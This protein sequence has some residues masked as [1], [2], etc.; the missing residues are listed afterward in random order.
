DA[1]VTGRPAIEPLAADLR[2]G[3]DGK[4]DA[5]LKI[6]AGLLGVGLDEL[7]HRDQARRQRRLAIVGVAAT[8]GCILFAGLALAAW[9]A[10]NEAEAQR[11]LAAQKSL[12]A[13]RTAAF[14]V[15]LF[16]E[17]DPSEARGRSI[18]VSEVLERG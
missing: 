13:Q 11:A 3:A 14:M 10:R 6:V 15:S 5:R 1:D 9:V 8:V 2:P 12:T 17:S 4:A 7:R 18:T 16:R